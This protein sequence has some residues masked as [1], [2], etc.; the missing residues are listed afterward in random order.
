VH[1]TLSFCLSVVKKSVRGTYLGELVEALGGAAADLYAGPEPLG[2]H[3]GGARIPERIV[4]DD[5]AQRRGLARG[6]HAAGGRGRLL[7]SQTGHGAHLLVVDHDVRAQR[8]AE[9]AERSAAVLQRDLA[10]VLRL[11]LGEAVE[12]DVQRVQGLQLE[13]PQLAGGGYERR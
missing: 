13:L 4:R 10:H 6:R 1:K 3:H 5:S 12:G 8:V 11:L 9:V 2:A 7:A